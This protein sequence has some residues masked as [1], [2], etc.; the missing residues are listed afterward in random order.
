MLEASWVSV[1][2]DIFRESMSRPI[3]SPGYK[4]FPS[5]LICSHPLALTACE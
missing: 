1:A 2:E 3:R 4:A 5:A